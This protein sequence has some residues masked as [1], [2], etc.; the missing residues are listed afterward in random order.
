[1]VERTDLPFPLVMLPAA[2]HYG[3]V[4][5]QTFG[6]TLSG[7]KWNF[8]VCSHTAAQYNLSKLVEYYVSEHRLH[9]HASSVHPNLQPSLPF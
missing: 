4:P 3:R 5:F 7:M 9:I 2:L 1:M 8:Q 6:S